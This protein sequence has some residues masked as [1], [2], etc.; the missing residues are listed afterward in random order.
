MNRLKRLYSSILNDYNTLK[1]S[2][3]N[4]SMFCADGML[5]YP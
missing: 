1:I 3:K 2:I 4:A 5:I